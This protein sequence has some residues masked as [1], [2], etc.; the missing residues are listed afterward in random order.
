[1]NI[2]KPVPSMEIAM[3]S[4][5]KNYEAITEYERR[6]KTPSYSKVPNFGKG[7][8]SKGRKGKE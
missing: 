4:F 8:P 1:M 6:E 5:D 7:T 3:M 2:I